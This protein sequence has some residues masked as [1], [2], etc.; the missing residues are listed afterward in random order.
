MS[1][2]QPPGQK[3]DPN[4]APSATFQNLTVLGTAT[5]N[6]G[7]A[8]A[9]GPT[10]ST[11]PAGATGPT[12]STGPAGGGATGES[13]LIA[14]AT[15]VNMNAAGDTAMTLSAFASGKFYTTDYTIIINPGADISATTV[16]VWSA[17]GGTG[18][19]YGLFAPATLNTAGVHNFEGSAG[20]NAVSGGA[21]GVMQN[22]APLVNVSTPQ[23]APATA[24]FYVYGRVFS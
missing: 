22:T 21:N 2:H 4:N 6:F 13:A 15:G 19:N 8:G 9:T 7:G 10:G 11:G 23:G 18:Q 3:P 17:A 24:D 1:S 5:G 20:I 12:G 14:S 16:G